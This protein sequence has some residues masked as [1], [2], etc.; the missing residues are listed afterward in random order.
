[1]KTKIRKIIYSI[2][3]LGLLTPV[4]LLAYAPP[5]GTTL[6]TGSVTNIVKTIMTW[7]LG[8]VGFLGVI[9]FAIAGILYLTSAG[10]EDR[11]GTAKKAMT[12]SIVGV[13][14]ALLGV[15]IIQAADK[16]LNAK[17]DF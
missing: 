16:M 13:I 15:V 11:I 7:I 17:S 14:V 4:M 10:D 6:P 12:W 3:S 9:G 1:M 8:M 5:A 2:T